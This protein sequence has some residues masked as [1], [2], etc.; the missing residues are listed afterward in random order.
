[1]DGVLFVTPA[2]GEFHEEMV[3]RLCAV[4]GRHLEPWPEVHFAPRSEVALPPGNRIEPDLLGYRAE[5]LPSQWLDVSA[6][7]VVPFPLDLEVLFRGLP[8]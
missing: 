1:M 5:R 7:P 6:A 3:A 2:P 4:L 8:G